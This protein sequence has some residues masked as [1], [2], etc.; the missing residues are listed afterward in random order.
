MHG[1]RIVRPEASAWPVKPSSRNT[2]GGSQKYARCTALE[3][4]L[5][6]VPWPTRWSHN[7]SAASLMCVARPVSRSIATSSST[8]SHLSPLPFTLVGSG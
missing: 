2:L 7:A 5:A 1:R 4:L 8:L 6:H 3:A